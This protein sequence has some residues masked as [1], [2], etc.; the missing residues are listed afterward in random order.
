[1]QVRLS[2]VI[3]LAYSQCLIMPNF[4]FYQG[5]HAGHLSHAGQAGNLSVP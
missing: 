2:D 5:L 3:L 1:M 4:G